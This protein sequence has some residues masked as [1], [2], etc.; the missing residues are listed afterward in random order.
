MSTIPLSGP[1]LSPA[2]Q[3]GYAKNGFTVARSLLN[4]EEVDALISHYMKLHEQGFDNGEEIEARLIEGDP[5]RQWPRLMHPHKRDE[6]TLRYLLDPRIKSALRELMQD[7]PLAAQSMFY[8]KPPGA[9]GHALH[10]DQ[11]FLRVEPGTCVAAW[12]ALDKADQE[13]G[14]MRLV[15]GMGDLPLL[16]V[17]P[18][19]LSQSW[20]QITVPLPEDAQ[21]VELELE[22]GDVLFFNG[23]APHGSRP[24]TSR[25]RFRRSLI[26]HYVPSGARQVSGWY[27][28]M[29]D[30]Q[31]KPVSREVSPRGGPCG[32]WKEE[33]G[34]LNLTILDPDF[35]QPVKEHE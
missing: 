28:P 32:V 10:Q 4:R 7:E 19:D 11:Y 6:T 14:G 8:Y 27:Q 13:N 33:D 31:G 26:F 23:W 30:F 2:H 12:I 21:A 35:E 3:S 18:A 24:N 25:D 29:L 34:K 17:K 1:I 9:R 15:P 16:C 5:L 22:P 20:A